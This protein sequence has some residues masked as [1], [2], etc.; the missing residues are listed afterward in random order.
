MVRC[1]FVTIIFLFG[2]TNSFSQTISFSEAASLTLPTTYKDV[3]WG[4][5]DNDGDLDILATSTIFENQGENIFILDI[6]F[7]ESSI[8]SDWGDINNDGY[9]DVILGGSNSL[10]IYLNQGSSFTK[11]PGLD[12]P[13]VDDGNFSLGDYDNDGDLDLLQTGKSDGIAY[14][15]IFRNDGN[16]FKEQPGIDLQQ[17]S[18]G[19]C[20]WVDY[21]ND[22]DLD[23]H[24]TGY[25]GVT[26]SFAQLY[27]NNGD[28]TFSDHI[29]LNGSWRNSVTWGDTDGD[30][31]LDAI[32]VGDG[33]KYLYR[34]NSGSSF[35]TVYLSNISTMAYAS[36]DFGDY[37][38]DGAIDLLA[39]G[40]EY[41]TPDYV[42]K[43]Y[44]N[45]GNN[46]FEEVTGFSLPG[47]SYGGSEWGDYD[48][49][50]DLD[51]LISGN[52][53]P[54]GSGTYIYQNEG[55]IVNTQPSVPVLQGS[56][57][58]G[59]DVILKW[60]PSTDDSTLSAS[61]SYNLCVENSSSDTLVPAHALSNGFR[62]VVSLGN[63]QLDTSFI[64]KNLPIRHRLQPDIQLE[65]QDLQRFD[66]HYS[67]RSFLQR[68]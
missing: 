5:Y 10:V 25:S 61:I 53:Y 64:L 16:S 55:G 9:L 18:N 57:I 62:K 37:D 23:I 49:D 8:K 6:T 40:Y 66:L 19:W 59:A 21:D 29:S 60:D 1:F 58:D 52:L 30:G 11:Y 35:T 39:T 41:Y 14:T 26:Q 67:C 33:S 51:I 22:G 31:D 20:T 38:N 47:L 2:S 24:L 44:R 13:G 4:D 42:T 65:L 48:N 34:N 45:T 54:S 12:H 63:A 36:L 3:H 28:G 56:D 27:R 7:S 68:Q 43:V 17:I 15:S 46:S 50:G 32:T